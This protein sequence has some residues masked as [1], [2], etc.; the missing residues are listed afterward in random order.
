MPALDDDRGR[1]PGAIVSL[2]EAVSALTST[3][4][5]GISASETGELELA[6]IEVEFF[7]ETKADGGPA[8]GVRFWVVD[9]AERAQSHRVTIRL[10]RGYSGGA[11]GGSSAAPDADFHIADSWEEGDRP[12]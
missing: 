6:D 5:D 12:N 7:F 1:P 3:L 9:A 8:G 10:R 2:A 4:S 11:T